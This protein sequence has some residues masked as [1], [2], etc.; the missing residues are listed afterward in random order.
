MSE[1]LLA[2]P[3]SRIFMVSGLTFRS[4]LHVESISVQGV[5]RWSCF[6]FLHVAVQFS[7][8]Y[9][10][11][12]LFP[13]AYSFLLCQRLIDHTIVRLFLGFLF[14]SIDLCVYFCSST[15]L[16]W[17]PQLCNIKSRIVKSAVSFSR[18]LWLFMVFCDS[19]QMLEL[20]VLVL[21]KM[22]SIFW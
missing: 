9:L 22:L 16:F 19:I 15:T 13:I 3:Y 5:G 20:F 12:R 17:L 14:C 8:H 1:K 18:F 10:L 2:V 7:Q 21:W 4:F 11:K 6:M